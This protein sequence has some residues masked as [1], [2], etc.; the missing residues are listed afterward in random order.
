MARTPASGI[1]H[2]IRAGEYGAVI[3]SV[4]A[5]L[6]SLTFAGRDLVVP[7]GADEV[8]PAHRGATLA[9]WPN[10]VVDGAYTFGGRDFQDDGGEFRH[11]GR[12]D[13]CVCSI[14]FPSAIDSPLCS[15]SRSYLLYLD[16]PKREELSAYSDGSFSLA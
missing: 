5:T 13:A 16:A 14:P 1:Q 10:R 6:R 9:P 8:R 11:F 15:C 2:T 12:N 4:G 7:F 3:A